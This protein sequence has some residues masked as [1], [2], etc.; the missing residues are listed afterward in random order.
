MTTNAYSANH[1]LGSGDN[2]TLVSLKTNFFTL[3]IPAASSLAAAFT[4]Q[5]INADTWYSGVGRA[6][7]ITVAGQPELNRFIWPSQSYTLVRNDDG[8][9]W[10]MGSVQR[11]KLPPY[12]TQV[13][14]FHIDPAA[15]SDTLGV[16]DGLAAGAGA[17]ASFDNGVSLIFDQVD[18]NG[19]DN[20]VSRITFLGAAPATF[21]ATASGT[22]LTATSVTGTIH[23]GDVVKGSNGIPISPI[24]KILSQTSGTTGAAGVYVT[25]QALTASAASCTACQVETNTLHFSPHGNFVGAQGGQGVTIDGNG[26]VIS[27]AFQVYHAFVGYVQNFDF[28]L[29][30]PGYAVTVDYGARLFLGPGN[31]FGTPPANSSHIYVGPA[32][33]LILENYTISGT[34]SGGNHMVV[35]GGSIFIIGGTT[36]SFT[37]DMAMNAF[38]AGYGCPNIDTAGISYSTGGHTVTGLAYQLTGPAYYPNANLYPGLGFSQG[39]HD[40]WSNWT[41]ISV[42]APGGTLAATVNG[43]VRVDGNSTDI[44]ATLTITDASTCVGPVSIQ[45]PYVGTLAVPFALVG[46]DTVTKEIVFGEVDVATAT[47]KLYRRDGFYQPETGDVIVLNGRYESLS[48]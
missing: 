20:T 29:A 41:S 45:T 3:A 47:I 42:T 48:N 35:E 13:V 15:G 32:S 1:T 10:N 7:Y 38:I 2:G 33:R 37:A 18:F 19:N 22:N 23:V 46:Y 31:N 17:F 36:V 8:V 30:I 24:T 5:I 28:Q 6:K 27:G 44:Q 12:T 11:T 21:T 39:Q 14:T 16:T 34:A 40:P 25:S 26:M 9:A 4:C 43:R